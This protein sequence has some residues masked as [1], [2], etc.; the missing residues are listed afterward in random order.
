[1]RTLN[2]ETFHVA[3]CSFG[4]V[5]KLYLCAVAGVGLG[6][7][8]MKEFDMGILCLSCIQKKTQIYCGF[9]S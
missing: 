8:L 7:C 2:S 9:F 6:G 4:A 3:S 1:M 5:G